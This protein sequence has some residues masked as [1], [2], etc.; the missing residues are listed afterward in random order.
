VIDLAP[1]HQFANNIREDIEEK[2]GH[3]WDVK[4]LIVEFTA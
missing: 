2:V 3:L 1:D 4:E